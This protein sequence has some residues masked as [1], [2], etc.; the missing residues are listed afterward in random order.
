[1]GAGILDSREPNA[2]GLRV[3]VPSVAGGATDPTAVRPLPPPC[4]GPSNYLDLFLTRSVFFSRIYRRGGGSRA[5]FLGFRL[6]CIVLAGFFSSVGPP[7]LCDGSSLPRRRMATAGSGGKKITLKSSDGE[8]FEVEETVAMESQTIKHMIEDDCADNGIPLPNVTSKILSK[9]IE[10][11][12]KHVEASAAASTTKTSD[13]VS[14]GGERGIEDELKS[15]DADF[16]KV[17]QATLFD[18]ILVRLFGGRSRQLVPFTLVFNWIHYLIIISAFSLGFGFLC[19][20]PAYERLVLAK[21]QF[22]FYHLVFS[23]LKIDYPLFSLSTLN[24]PCLQIL[25]VNC[26][27]I[28]LGS[29]LTCFIGKALSRDNSLSR[30]L[31]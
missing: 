29:T 28:K 23:A 1:M 12:K 5:V 31:V 6:V 20:Y 25:N 3:G 18:L 27:C 24:L 10:Y 19:C 13:G 21:N 8:E 11:C 9:V 16:V 15:W 17:D 26:A 4:I 30:L 2:S 14:L 7:L 22:H